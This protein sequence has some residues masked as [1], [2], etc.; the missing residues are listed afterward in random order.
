MLLSIRGGEKKNIITENMNT[1]KAITVIT[2]LAPEVPRR[3]M[4]PLPLSDSLSPAGKVSG[5]VTEDCLPEP[6]L[7]L[8]NQ[9]TYCNS[10]RFPLASLLRLAAGLTD[11]PLGGV[12]TLGGFLLRRLAQ[13]PHGP[14]V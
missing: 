3:C 13:S 7:S 6:L 8:Q 12:I 14:S 11:S 4:L 1:I 9:W 10:L 5:S 2:C